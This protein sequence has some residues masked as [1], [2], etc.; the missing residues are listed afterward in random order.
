M[1][2]D[3]VDVADAFGQTLEIEKKETNA[4]PQNFNLYQNS[5]NPFN[6]TTEIR[7]DLDIPAHVTLAVYNVLGQEVIRLADRDYPAGSHSIMWDGVDNDNHQVASGI[8]FYRIKAA[9]HSASR[10]MV[11]LK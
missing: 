5:P 9:D 4:L 11:L 3:R 7:F 10:K 8:Y 1:Y 2:L 6:P